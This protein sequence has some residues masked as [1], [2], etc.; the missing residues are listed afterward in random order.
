MTHAIGVGLIS[1]NLVKKEL[2]ERQLHEIH[3]NSKPIVIQTSL[4]IATHK[5]RD[6][7]TMHLIRLIE[8]KWN[9]IH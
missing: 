7:K 2:A 5:L 4:I 6:P 3:L 1:R 9:M 8:Q